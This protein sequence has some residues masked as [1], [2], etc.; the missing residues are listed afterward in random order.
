MFCLHLHPVILVTC[1]VYI[2]YYIT[3]NGTSR[4]PSNVDMAAFLASSVAGG[5]YVSDA[6]TAS[7]H[8]EIKNRINS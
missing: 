3:Y 2:M 8:I 5:L 1:F 7:A 6:Y 4:E